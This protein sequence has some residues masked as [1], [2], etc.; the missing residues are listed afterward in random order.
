MRLAAAAARLTANDAAPMLAC[1]NL[2]VLV[3]VEL[4]LECLGGRGCS[5]LLRLLRN[6]G[7]GRLY[8]VGALYFV[9]HMH[10]QCNVGGSGRQ[11]RLRPWTREWLS[12]LEAPAISA[13]D[14]PNADDQDNHTRGS[15]K[16]GD[17]SAI[18]GRWVG[19][20]A[21]RQGL[22]C[23]GTIRLELKLLDGHSQCAF[24]LTRVQRCQ[25]V[26]RKSCGRT[27]RHLYG[28]HNTNACSARL[29][30]DGACVNVKLSGKI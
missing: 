14:E 6:S 1:T 25:A 12:Q 23:R 24:Q 3:L 4:V 9:T 18:A 22:R 15:T 30:T 29:Q 8:A 28:A 19:G 21:G 10:V 27:G 7:R 20:R 2:F 26:Q 16:T 13:Q 17:Q 11:R 5:R